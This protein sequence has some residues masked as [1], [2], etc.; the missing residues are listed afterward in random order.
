M[1][2]ES[3][4]SRLTNLLEK[5]RSKRFI[6]HIIKSYIP[7]HEIEKVYEEPGDKFVCAITNENLISLNE[8]KK[9]FDESN[10]KEKFDDCEEKMFLDGGYSEHPFNKKIDGREMGVTSNISETYIS[11]PTF[12]VLYEW[13]VKEYFKGNK[14]IKRVL[15]NEEDAMLTKAKEFRETDKSM[16][17]ELSKIESEKRTTTTLGDLDQLKELRDKFNDKNE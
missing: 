15:R 17:T 9:K 3:I 14:K 1:N 4:K 5:D 6:E 10:E 2:S 11:Y 13:A 8:G 16:N 12:L 7:P